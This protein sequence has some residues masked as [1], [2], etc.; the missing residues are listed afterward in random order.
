[1]KNKP[2]NI[3]V[4]VIEFGKTYQYKESNTWST[5]YLEQRR[6]GVQCTWSTGVQEY[7]IPEVQEYWSTVYLEYRRTVY[8]E[9]RSTVYLK[10]RSIG[11]QYTWS[12]EVEEY[13]I[14]EV[15]EYWS[16]VYLEYRSTV[17][18]QIKSFIGPQVNNIHINKN[19]YTIKYI[20]C[21]RGATRQLRL[22]SHEL[23][24]F[25]KIM[26]RFKRCAMC[27]YGAHKC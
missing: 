21:G 22:F 27:L 23:P 18:N 14:H 6:I 19:D 12:T 1:M 16:T 25:K 20:F 24:W 5:V 13:S 4:K 26:I 3:L 10:Y 8:L 9:Y 11:V 17:L 15:E 2:L 7:S